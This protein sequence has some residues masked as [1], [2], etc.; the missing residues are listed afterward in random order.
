MNTELLEIQPSEL[1]FIFE[2]RKQS[3][4][5]V[6]LVNK[7][8]HHVAFKV[9]TTSPKKYCVRPNTGIVAPKS[10]CD[11]I[12]T[13]QAQRV[14]PPEMICKDKFLLQCAAVPVGTAEEDIT[15]STFAKDGKYVEEKK[16]RVIL[17]SPPNSP[18]HSPINGTSKQ[19][20]VYE[21]L[22]LK[23]YHPNNA[24]NFSP[25]QTVIGDVEEAIESVRDLEPVKNY[26]VEE[27]VLTKDVEH[28]P[29]NDVESKIKKDLV[30]TKDVEHEPM[31]DVESKIMKDL[32]ELKVVKDPEEHK[33]SHDIEFKIMKDEEELKLAKDIEEVKLKLK[34]FE[35]KLHE[36]EV[37]ISKLTEEKRLSKV[38][39]ESLQHELVLMRSKRSGQKL[40][41]G[42]PLLF[43]FMVA[44]VSVLLGY[45]LHRA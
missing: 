9:K 3:S 1:K 6:R 42:F 12:V 23:D 35:S 8:D 14:F 45:L 41:A 43:V 2:L 34:E 39:R 4:C 11:F 13:M 30:L 29:R 10:V 18:L 15:S 38:D 31:N 7:S 5:S 32:E 44:L 25:H 40:Q 22:M 21:D 37:T 36:A 33:P 16:L 24:E 19:E 17:V 27:V 28:E 20:P 26:N